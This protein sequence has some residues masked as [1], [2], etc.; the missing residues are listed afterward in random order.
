M[1]VYDQLVNGRRAAA[2]VVALGLAGSQAGHLLTYQLRFGV[3]AQQ[4]QSSG[5][6]GYF[7]GVAKT[8]VGLASLGLLGAL[9]MI[10]LGRVVAGKRIDPTS[11]PSLVSLLA[12]L[13][14]L[15][16]GC[17]GTQETI[18]ALAGGAHLGSV[19]QILL[20]GALG[21]L[22][23]ALVASVALRWLLAR[24]GPVVSELR[25]ALQRPERKIVLAIAP[26]A[27]TIAYAPAIACVL[28][29]RSNPR[30]GPPSS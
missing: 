3:A 6:H 26:A 10:G 20:W 17:F 29:V 11:A 1:R 15:Q 19:S 22:P 13:Y 12:V 18:E 2:A 23:V 30:R 7:P 21:Q 27:P 8:G 24:L 5:V 14:T 4:L 16:L 28:H 25:I 9:F